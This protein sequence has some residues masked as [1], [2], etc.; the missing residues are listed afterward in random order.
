MRAGKEIGL[1]WQ[2]DL[3]WVGEQLVQIRRC[4]CYLRRV[5][6][7]HRVMI[8]VLHVVLGWEDPLL[9]ERL[10]LEHGEHMLLQGHLLPILI[11]M[12]HFNYTHAIKN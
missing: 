8:H 7:R 5:H 10:L 1:T 2:A 6:N 4:S 12:M 11:E 3:Q 9:V